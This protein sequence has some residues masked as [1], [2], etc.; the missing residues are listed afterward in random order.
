MDLIQLNLAT[1]KTE[2]EALRSSSTLLLRERN[3]H[4]REMKR[5]TDEDNAKYRDL[6]FR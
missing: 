1:L 4:I 6:P 5:L 2:E 3:L